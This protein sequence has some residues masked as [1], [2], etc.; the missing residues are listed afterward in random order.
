VVIAF[1]ASVEAGKFAFGGFEAD[2]EALSFAEP[3][4]HL[5]FGDA[6]VKIVD[7]FEEAGSLLW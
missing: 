2:L 3:A 5:G 1:Q 6:L 4:V 7:D